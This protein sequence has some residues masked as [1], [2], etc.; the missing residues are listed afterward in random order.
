MMKSYKWTAVAVAIA[1][2]CVVGTAAQSGTQAERTSENAKEMKVT[3]CVR[4]GSAI[5]GAS[6]S[7]S[8]AG[9][10]SESAKADSYVLTNAT[11]GSSDTATTTGTSGSATGSSTTGTSYVLDGHESD[12]KKHLGHRIEITGTASAKSD[13]ATKGSE[14]PT[15][16]TMSKGDGSTGPH[17]RVSSIRMIAA[18]C[19][20]GK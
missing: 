11:V 13:A 17:L 18:D 1:A 10:T 15:P 9:S 12:L 2:G 5:G 16:T 8:T 3:G 20:S 19:S 6:A 14:T 7:T 4:D